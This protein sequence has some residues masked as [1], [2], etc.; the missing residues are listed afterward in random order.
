MYGK[1]DFWYLCLVG[2]CWDCIYVVRVSDYEIDVVV[3]QVIVIGNSVICL[4]VY[5]RSKVKADG[6]ADKL[7]GKVVVFYDGD[8]VEV[9]AGCFL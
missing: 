9:V 1:L 3:V 7:F 4:C 6:N 2:Y 5:A 8:Y